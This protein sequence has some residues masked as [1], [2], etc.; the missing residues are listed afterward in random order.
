MLA[1]PLNK[2]AYGDALFYPSP[3]GTVFTY[4]D[5]YNNNAH[6]IYVKPRDST[7]WTEAFPGDMPGHVRYSTTVYDTSIIIYNDWYGDFYSYSS[8]FG[9][10]WRALDLGSVGAPSP[11]RG[12]R[13]VFNVSD[14]VVACWRNDGYRELDLTTAKQSYPT[15]PEHTGIY[16]RSGKRV[17]GTTVYTDDK[18]P[19]RLFTSADS[20]ATWSYI[21][22]VTVAKTGSV[23]TSDMADGKAF[24]CTHIHRRGDSTF[25]LTTAGLQVLI[26]TDAGLTWR[27]CSGT[28]T[29]DLTYWGTTHENF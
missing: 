21:D 2:T 16:A 19:A 14:S 23:I 13:N 18:R 11:T 24:E 1:L 6:R 20:G 8:D 28:I 15:L 7:D 29:S 22:N 26:S 5:G 10:T 25:V 12:Y 17:L 4:W 27:A 3:F 9:K